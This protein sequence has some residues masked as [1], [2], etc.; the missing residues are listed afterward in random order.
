M[1]TRDNL[2]ELTKILADAMSDLLKAH[3]A[4]TA[5][6]YKESLTVGI[7]RLRD[8]LGPLKEMKKQLG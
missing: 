1:M 2:P 7:E 3:G 5:D 4:K 6:D 8:V